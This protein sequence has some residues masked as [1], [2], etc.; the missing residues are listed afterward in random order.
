M[1][2]LQTITTNFTAG[3]FSPRLRGRVDLE[4]YNASAEK[5]ENIVVLRQGGATIRPSLD[6]KGPIKVAAQT[7]RIIPFVYS[8]TDAYILELGELYL[9]IWKNGA[10]VESSPGVPYEVATPWTAAQVGSLDFTQGADTLILTHPNVYPQRIQRFGDASWRVSACPFQPGAI[11]EGGHR[12]SGTNMTISAGTVGAGRTVTA[13][14]GFF[15]PADVGRVI[16]WGNG[17]ATITAFGSTISV[18][19]TVTA[20]FDALAAAGPTWLL[21]GT[22]QTALTPSVDK[23]VGATVTLTA[24]AN[25]WRT[26]DNGRFVEI[27][28]GLVEIVSTNLALVATGII[29]REL[30]GVV[31]APADAWVLK[32]PVW[33]DV[34]GYPRTCTLFQ[35]RLWFAGTAKFPQTEWGSQSGLF[36]DFTPGTDDAAAV[37]KTIDSDD[38]N[39]IEYLVSVESLVALTFGGEYETRGGIEKPITQLNAQLAK[40]SKWGSDAVRPEEAGK[41]MLV[42]QRGGRA[43]RRLKREDVAGFSLIDVSVFSEHLLADGVRS[44]AW[45]QSPEQVMWICTGAGKLLALTYSDEQNTVAFCSGNASGFVEW[46]ATIPDGAVD[47]TYALVRRTINGATVRY[48][49]RINWDAPP[50][51]DCRKQVSGAASATWPGFGHL[52]GQTVQVLG[53]GVHLGSAVVTGG[54]I[55]LPRPASTLSAGIGYIARM[56]LQAPEVGTGTGTSQA[57]AQ[58]NNQIYVRFLETLGCKVN[59][60]DIGFR[61]LGPGVLDTPIPPFTGIKQ[62]TDLGWADGEAPIELVQDQ[63]YPWT[64]L[65]VVRNFTVNQG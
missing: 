55:T 13:S 22:P 35:Q 20:A 8:R 23:P 24:A 64:V 43:I 34:D 31:A 56:R 26:E 58:A 33:N 42:V 28:G 32:G 6:Y 39:V 59:G 44:M 12:R 17:L 41:D 21:E 9:R 1:P 62:I 54:V 52:E 2:K 3:E 48:I 38:I 10:L 51:Q 16:G 45:E 50:G 27:N 47:A 60:D 63:P 30:T 14:A 11:Y 57:Q 29:R 36:F 4:K 53:D 61:Q 7:V 25:A 5:L 46:L 40:I 65:A 15:Q 49:E 37:Y 18:T 19:A